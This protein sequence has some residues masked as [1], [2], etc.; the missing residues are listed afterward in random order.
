M[1][2]LGI[3][4]DS[5]INIESRNVYHSGWRSVTRIDILRDRAQVGETIFNCP[6]HVQRSRLHQ[7]GFRL[8]GCITRGSNVKFG[9]ER[10]ISLFLF[11][12]NGGKCE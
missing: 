9:A 1:G 6:F 5:Y 11:A 12:D 7:H 10:T 2:N 4:P 8:F 3:G